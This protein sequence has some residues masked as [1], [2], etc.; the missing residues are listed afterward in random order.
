[1]ALVMALSWNYSVDYYMDCIMAV[2]AM[3]REEMS[4]KV[5]VQALGDEALASTKN[6]LPARFHDDTLNP[7]NSKLAIVHHYL[8][9]HC[10]NM[11]PR[12]NCLGYQNI[13][14]IW[15]A[16]AMI[17]ASEFFCSFCVILFDNPQLA[18]NNDFSSSTAHVFA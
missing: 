11:D 15:V 6:Q 2:V 8:F 5:H 3:G 10:Y 16:E 17:V 4:W 13:L 9:L 1:M 7:H 18:L 12:W 14:V